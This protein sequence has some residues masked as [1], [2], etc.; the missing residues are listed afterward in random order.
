MKCSKTHDVLHTVYVLGFKCC[1][2]SAKLSSVAVRVSVP[3]RL[4]IDGG[5]NVFWLAC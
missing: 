2:N 1:T 3:T 4:M 5:D